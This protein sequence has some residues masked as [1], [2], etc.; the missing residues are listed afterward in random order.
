MVA[1]E[2]SINSLFTNHTN[3][4][5][6][7]SLNQSDFSMINKVFH[8]FL[9]V[10][11]AL[12]ATTKAE[13]TPIVGWDKQLFPSYIIGTAAIKSG[14]SQASATELGDI[15][16]LLGIEIV[17]PHDDTEIEVTIECS[18][19]LESSRFVGRLEKQGETYKIFPKIKY[20]IR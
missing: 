20:P 14:D 8:T 10:T 15:N 11:A 6:T 2:S 9:I 17:A 4:V 7:L 19:F 12:A 18:E 5:I 1:I 3:P 16:G 13:F